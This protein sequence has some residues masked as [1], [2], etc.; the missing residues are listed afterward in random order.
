MYKFYFVLGLFRYLRG[1]T[2]KSPEN[3]ISEK[4]TSL[5]EQSS[6]VLTTPTDLPTVK[7]D[8]TNITL[9]YIANLGEL[10]SEK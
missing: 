5:Y 7:L 1:S 9:S 8:I 3:L 2:F 4:G 10:G 6:D